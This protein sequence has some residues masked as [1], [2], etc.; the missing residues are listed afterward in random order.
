MKKTLFI[1]LSCLL[2]VIPM[3]AQQNFNI[4][5]SERPIALSIVPHAGLNLSSFNGS[6][7]GTRFSMRAGANAGVG[8]ELRFIKRN[9]HTPIADGLLGVYA[10]VVFEMGGTN[11]AGSSGVSMLNIGIPVRVKVYPW[12]WFF[13]EAGPEFFMNISNSPNTATIGNLEVTFGS[14]KFNDLKI[15]VGAGVNLGNFGVGAR[16]LIGTSK[17]ASS[18][19]WKCNILQIYLSYNIPVL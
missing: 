19:P 2:F 12:K 5:S 3:K 8:A 14:H 11:A 10:G 4:V 13:V 6:D 15:G 17:L 18:I 1:A 16:Y 7:S 9:E